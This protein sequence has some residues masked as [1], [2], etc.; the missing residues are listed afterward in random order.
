[1]SYVKERVNGV[2]EKVKRK[3]VVPPCSIK[4]QRNWGE[5]Y[6]NYFYK[7]HPPSF[8]FFTDQRSITGPNLIS[9]E[10]T[11]QSIHCGSQESQGLFLAS[12]GISLFHPRKSALAVGGDCFSTSSRI[13]HFT[14]KIAVQSAFLSYAQTWSWNSLVGLWWSKCIVHT[15]LLPPRMPFSFTLLSWCLDY[16]T[17]ALYPSSPH[18]YSFFLEQFDST[19]MSITSLLLWS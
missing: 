1:M 4:L 9:G 8:P 7:L 19:F 11:T 16:M 14:W 18:I 2:K 17:I 3:W 13:D 5:L 10:G 6:P 15:L 12:H